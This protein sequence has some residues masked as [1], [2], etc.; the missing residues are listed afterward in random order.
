M[1]DMKGMFTTIFTFAFA[2]AAGISQSVSARIAAAD[3]GVDF[4]EKSPFGVIPLPFGVSVIV[5]RQWHFNSQEAVT[6]C[7]I[8]SWL[9][10][11]G[12]S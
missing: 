11:R 9:S 10:V 5:R 8:D 3:N 1:G 6:N 12:V 4:G 7:L 2:L